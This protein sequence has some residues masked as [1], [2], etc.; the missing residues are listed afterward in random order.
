[1]GEG[2]LWEAGEEDSRIVK[3]ELSWT[4]SWGMQG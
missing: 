1:M 3:K 4:V 2:L